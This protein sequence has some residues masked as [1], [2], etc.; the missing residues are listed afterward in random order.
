MVGFGFHVHL[1]AA[2]VIHYLTTDDSEHGAE[3]MEQDEQADALTEGTQQKEPLVGEMAELVNL[4]LY[5]LLADDEAKHGWG[6][7]GELLAESESE[8]E[9]LLHSS[10]SPS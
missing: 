3:V 10:L 6:V 5:L 2:T 1:V 4:H 9:A 8:S 7:D